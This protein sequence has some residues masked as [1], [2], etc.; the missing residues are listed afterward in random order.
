[1]PFSTLRDTLDWL[2]QEGTEAAFGPKDKQ[3]DW[4]LEPSAVIPRNT[5]RR[6]LF[7]LTDPSGFIF[8]R[9]RGRLEKEI[10][11]MAAQGGFR[12]LK[13]Q[14]VTIRD[15]SAMPDLKGIDHQM[16]SAYI[17]SDYSPRT[18]GEFS[19]V[20]FG[21]PIIMSAED[22]T[23]SER[24]T[25]DALWVAQDEAGKIVQDIDKPT[26]KHKLDV[27]PLFGLGIA[28]TA[29]VAGLWALS[30]NVGK[31]NKYA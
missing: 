23:L 31:E 29:V 20:L 11:K 5:Y 25:L 4:I 12:L 16:Y 26:I 3:P 17:A 30:T 8:E 6:A 19:A 14:P 15:Y 7:L 21:A 1:M 24:A 18:L 13:M 2:Y 22:A 27:W 28:V 10:P 9:Y